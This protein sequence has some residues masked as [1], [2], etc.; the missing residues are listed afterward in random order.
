[1][2]KI[3]LAFSTLLLFACN[4]TS[5]GI[6]PSE[7]KDMAP[8]LKEESSLNET[9]AGYGVSYDWE[10]EN[11]PDHNFDV[12]DD[13]ETYTVVMDENNSGTSFFNVAPAATYSKS[14]NGLSATEN[15]P[16][17]ASAPKKEEA[18]RPSDNFG[19]KA[20]KIVKDGTMTVRSENI[21]SSKF[22]MDKLIHHLNGYYQN[23]QMEEFQTRFVYD[24][25]IRVP[26]QN[27]DKLLNGIRKGGDK[28]ESK[29]INA[30]D[31]TEEYR[32][33]QTQLENKRAYLK[34]YQQLLAQAKNVKE[35]LMIE[36]YIRPLQSDIER[37]LGR[38]RYL[39]DKVGY[40][41]LSIQL[42]QPIEQDKQIIIED[43]VGFWSKLGSSFKNGWSYVLNFIINT[44]AIWPQ[45]IIAFLLFFFLRKKRHKIIAWFKK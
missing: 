2:K 20:L 38:L 16:V 25:V 39:D 24:L 6:A 40:S 31:V 37:H 41:T 23:E 28:I 19:Q 26:S 8:T 35:I 32:D 13:N 33:L 1:M 43:E 45:V 29:N 21:D 22:N 12:G 7:S 42:Y 36:D 44:I 5:D 17:G 10:S 18:K 15:K 3:L 9:E 34:R 14:Q 30:M 4:D 11:R 27:Y